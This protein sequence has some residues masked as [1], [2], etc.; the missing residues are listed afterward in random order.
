MPHVDDVT[1][2]TDEELEKQLT[3]ETE[4]AKSDIEFIKGVPIN[5]IEEQTIQLS[6]EARE[7]LTRQFRIKEEQ[8]LRDLE[9][10]GLQASQA[11]DKQLSQLLEQ[12]GVQADIT[13]GQVGAGL[14]GRGLL[15]STAGTRAIGDVTRAE[16]QQRTGQRLD[17]SERRAQLKAKITEARTIS[18]RR[19]EQRELRADLSLLQRVEDFRFAFQ[20]QDVEF[21]SKQAL[22]NLQLEADQFSIVSGAIGQIAGSIAGIL[23]ASQGGGGGGPD[24]DG[25]G[26]VGAPGGATGSP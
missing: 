18:E 10:R 23:L 16:F 14:A 21:A 19:E 4:T 13:R 25:P 24:F 6:G 11:L 15:R 8:A 20:I 3:K 26:D 1:K 17:V 7:S 9:S 22:L 2:L 12:T 5:Q